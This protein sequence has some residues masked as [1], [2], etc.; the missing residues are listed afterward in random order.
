MTQKRKWI[1]YIHLKF[2]IMYTPIQLSAIKLFGRKDL[3][4]G[5]VI[6]EE[7]M[8]RHFTVAW[9]WEVK[10]YW[11]PIWVMDWGIPKWPYKWNFEILWHIPHLEDL[12]RVAEE[13]GWSYYELFSDRIEFWKAVKR[14]WH[15]KIPY[16]PT[17]PLIDQPSLTEIINLFK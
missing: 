5:C 16:N 12:F 7:E 4:E 14:W 10:M 1:E 6:L 3:T 15:R 11:N 13:K 2:I 17:I 8:Q 9:V